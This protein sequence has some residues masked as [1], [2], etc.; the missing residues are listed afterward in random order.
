MSKRLF[1]TDAPRL[2]W[3]QFEAEGFPDPVSGVVFRAGE[4]LRGMPLGGIGTGCLDLNT[5]G[6]LGLCSIFNSFT[7]PRE[8]NCP[9]L[10]LTL[11]GRT[12][13]LTTAAG[14]ERSPAN[15]CQ[16]I[17]SW[18]HY[19]TSDLEYEL[20]IPVSVGLRAWA[21]FLPGD[22]ESSN[23]P[24]IFFDVSV[25]NL[26]NEKQSGVL[27]CGFPG[28]SESEAGTCSR[29]EISQEKEF[30]GVRVDW[31]QGSYL[32]TVLDSAWTGHQLMSPSSS[33]RQ[34]RV[35][36]DFELA[37]G[38]ERRIHFV[39]AWYV[40][41]WAGSAAHHFRHAYACR[42][43][44][45]IEVL[46]FAVD[47]RSEWL[48]S[49]LN[50]QSQIYSLQQL[51]LWLREQLVNVLHTITKDSFWAGDSIPPE[52]WYRP[53][54]LF[55]LTESP[56]T[57]PHICN[58]SDWYGILPMVFFFPDL[59]HSLLRLYVHF[60][61]PT[62]EIP[63]GVGEGADLLHPVH[64]MFQVM[65]SCVHIHLV[66]RLWQRDW[67][68]AI[69]REFYPSVVKAMDFL[70]TWDRDYDGL[71][72]LEADP[73]PGQFYGAWHWY[74]V[75]V[76]VSGFWLAALAMVERMAAAIGDAATQHRCHL[77]GEKAK[78]ALESKLWNGD[79]YL[80]YHDIKSQRKSDTILANQL[81][82]QWCSHLHGQPGVFPSNNVRKALSRI[83]QTCIKGT[84]H[85]AM[86]ATR[87]DGSLDHSAPPHSDGIFT[88]ECL[89]LAATLAY[90]NQ[91]EL[92][93]EIA[94]RMMSA[95]VLKDGSGWEMP[96]ILDAEGRV[97]HGNDFYQM[98]ILWA[99][100]LAFEGK[101]IHE[102]CASDGLVGQILAAARSGEPKTTPARR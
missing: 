5:N 52:S 9:L 53:L 30:C 42:F 41:R 37:P 93:E 97:I 29:Q 7:P 70:S 21:P 78:T 74:G 40:P 82:G 75:S 17:H 33:E 11:D 15:P 1:S 22:A 66:D 94:R 31:D 65:N 102:A 73:I 81:A 23:T 2:Q 58:P 59:V 99:L 32:L 13:P 39:L 72:E 12:S 48:Q 51:P 83:T 88:G 46:R 18:G 60:Q 92:G 96:N 27:T 69:L 79:S 25:R 50:W 56:R 10:W 62:G 80:L 68:P 101:S 43:K 54:G 14:V 85:G 44:N 24:A 16:Q 36:A 63:I 55:G 35:D 77:W 28:P 4:C 67:N 71:P 98:A 6:S 84:M 91:G 19:P 47:R 20:D 49:T 61:L 64:H 38:Q 95:I 45:V 57:T 34:A 86:N 26:S 87:P 89:C 76:H 100:P 90:E 8:L 3:C